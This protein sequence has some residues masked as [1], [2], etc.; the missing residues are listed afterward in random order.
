MTILEAII[1]G[2]VQGLTEFL[3]V[4]SSGHLSLVQHFFGISGEEAGIASIV[5]H[6]GTLAAVFIA[7]RQRIWQLIL[8]AFS[9]LKD[10]FTGKFKW[11][12]MNENRRMIM[13]IIISL[14]P[15]FGF[16]L[17]KDFFDGIAQDRDITV[18][19]FAFLYTSVILF[20][21]C[22]FGGN[23]K[24]IDKITV[25]N[26]L[27]IGI[28]QGIALVPGISRSGST[29]S[30]ALFC[31]M[32]RETA[33]EYSFILGIPVILAAAAVQL[34]D[35]GGGEEAIQIAPL[36][37]GFVMSAVVGLLA[38]KLVK[39]LIKDGKFKVFAYYTLILGILTV[40]AGFFE[41]SV[42]MTIPEYIFG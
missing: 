5:M 13:L 26:A 20:L 4:S 25:P 1:Q 41:K 32:K 12:K 31:G 34:K 37:V 38:I 36:A 14:L 11:S 17:F 10:L 15:L 18:E 6:L 2:I 16:V 40:A 8:E 30:S 21:S 22:R 7:F 27:T 23:D 9:L 35:L 19:G 28:F 42:G 29:I 39:W 3:P 33:V 24:D